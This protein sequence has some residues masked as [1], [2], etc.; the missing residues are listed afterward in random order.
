MA[1]RDR[2][3]ADAYAARHG[4]ATTHANYA[5]LVADPDV[6][7]VYNPLPNG[8]HG[9]WTMAAL[10]A[11]KHVLCEKP[12][13]A[14]RDEARGGGRGG[15]A[16]RSGG[17]RGLPLP[18]PPPGPTH[19][20]RGG[21]RGAGPHPPRRGLHLLPAPAVRRHPLS[22]RPGRRCA[23]GC[24]LLHRASASPG[25]VGTRTGARRAPGELGPGP[26][27][28]ARR[29]PGYARRAGVPQRR[30][31]AHGV[32]DVVP[33]VAAPVGAGLGRCRRDA[34]LQPARSPDRCTA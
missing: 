11:G 24:R 13:T 5:D 9:Q 10:E 20:R 12:F 18:V 8:L 29:G 30:H 2:S 4:I 7:A 32:L 17:G 3:R 14:N 31:R 19:A 6:D 23:H 27:P 1:A 28:I 34:G 22:P 33:L 26:A 25:G 15:T 16:H 21:Q